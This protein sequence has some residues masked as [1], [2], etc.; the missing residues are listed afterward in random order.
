MPH[1]WHECRGAD[2]TMDETVMI[3]RYFAHLTAAALLVGAWGCQGE[4][5][6]T[7]NDPQD[8][9]AV[10]GG[11]GGVMRPGG[12]E[13][14]DVCRYINTEKAPLKRLTEDEYN[15]VVGDLFPGIGF[16]EQTFAADEK[17]A[18]FDANI[19]AAVDKLV[20]EQYQGAAETIAGRVVNNIDSVRDCSG[21][22][23]DQ[24]STQFVNDIAARAFR[25]PLTQTEAQRFNVFYAS[26]ATAHG[27][28]T[29]LRMTIEAILQHPEFLYRGDFVEG[30]NPVV[31]LDDFQVAHR[32]SFFLW[33]SIPDQELWDAAAAGELS[34][35][36]ETV[37]AQARRMLQDDRARETLNDVAMKWL[38]MDGF[39]TISKDDPAFTPELQASMEAE[40]RAF[41]DHVLWEGDGTLETL[42]T[43]DYSFVDAETAALYGVEASEDGGLTRVTL[44]ANRAG[45]LTQPAVLAKHGYGAA[46][47]HR[48]MFVR[49][50]FFCGRPADPPDVLEN[51]PTTFEGQSERSKSEDRMAHSQCGG[52]HA[53]LDPMGL[54]F[55]N[56]DELGRWV[57]QDE[58]GNPV[59]GSSD[60]IATRDLNGPVNGAAELAGKL[61]AAPEVQACVSKQFLRYALGRMEDVDKD[62]CS[63]HQIETAMEESNGNIREALVAI[64]TSDAFLYGRTGD[65]Q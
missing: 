1:M 32:L 45:I 65:E 43:A 6:I 35:S 18:G 59:H 63:I 47:V 26:A 29:A 30:A 36:P 13:V 31:G 55:E 17:V 40:T 56:F 33:G 61:A 5:N 23:E 3:Q 38:R 28:D 25:R 48:G 64:A 4:I 22:N 2:A 9:V 12:G 20:A 27:S 41:I 54:T 19:L 14:E 10:P 53:Q 46:P 24:C 11:N 51:P 16:E 15:R 58:H 62:S 50:A 34:E 49:Q 52:C 7:A 42:L 37:E 21:A 60:I 39:H 44:G 8:V 57:E